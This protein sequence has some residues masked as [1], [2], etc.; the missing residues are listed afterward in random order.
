MYLFYATPLCSFDVLMYSPCFSP[1]DSAWICKCPVLCGCMHTGAACV[2][3]YYTNIG[4]FH[5]LS[6]FI[7]SPM[8]HRR[9]TALVNPQVRPTQFMFLLSNSCQQ[10]I[11]RPWGDLNPCL[12][13]DMSQLNCTIEQPVNPNVTDNSLSHHVLQDEIS[14]DELYIVFCSTSASHVIL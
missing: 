2:A 12:R 14:M 11:A 9:H 3:C 10:Q 1:P 4:N 7:Y 8:S 6:P 13:L 5:N